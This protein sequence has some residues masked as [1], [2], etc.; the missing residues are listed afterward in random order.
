M[1]LW[2]RTLSISP[3]EVVYINQHRLLLE[4]QPE[5]MRLPPPKIPN[6]WTVGRRQ[7]Q[8]SQ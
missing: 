6:Q 4:Q 3:A 5:H 1:K 7:P 2:D 8:P